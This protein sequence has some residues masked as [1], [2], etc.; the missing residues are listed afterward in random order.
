[1]KK[2]DELVKASKAE[3]RDVNLIA[4]LFTECQM[5]GMKLSHRDFMGPA[6]PLDLTY[7]GPKDHC[8]SAA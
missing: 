2:Y 7:N 8:S 3:V 5:A 4:R 1:M 6:R